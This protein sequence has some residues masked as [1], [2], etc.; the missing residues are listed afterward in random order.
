MHGPMKGTQ[1]PEN[2]GLYKPSQ[3]NEV[4]ARKLPTIPR[5]TEAMR[6]AAMFAGIVLLGIRA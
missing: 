6:D 3:T 5:V 4:P 2:A 1:C